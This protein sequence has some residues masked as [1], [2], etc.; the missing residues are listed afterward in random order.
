[1][2]IAIYSTAF[3]TAVTTPS[4]PPPP[5]APPFYSLAQTRL[6]TEQIGSVSHARQA[7]GIVGMLLIG[8]ANQHLP[9]T[10]LSNAY[11]GF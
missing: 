4:P 10:L 9:S 3:T 5:L 8:T 1:M 2:A 11:M 7:Y 6:I